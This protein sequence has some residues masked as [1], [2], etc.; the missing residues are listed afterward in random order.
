M[1]DLMQTKVLDLN[2][3]WLLASPDEEFVEE[4]YHNNRWQ[5]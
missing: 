3:W 1:A 5:S 2:I 4:H